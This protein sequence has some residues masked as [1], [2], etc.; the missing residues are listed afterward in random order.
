[1]RNSRYL[2]QRIWRAGVAK[3]R[4]GNA[5]VFCPADPVDGVGNTWPRG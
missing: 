4:I 2:S 5:V 1:M 3:P